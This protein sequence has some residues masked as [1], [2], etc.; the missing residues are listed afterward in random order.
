MN[1]LNSKNRLDKS[2]GIAE[3]ETSNAMNTKKTPWFLRLP[4]DI[5]RKIGLAVLAVGAL[6]LLILLNDVSAAEAKKGN[7]LT[8]NGMEQSW[9]VNPRWTAK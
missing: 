2:N 4:G 8:K 9:F 5:L 3:I 1:P 7:I 6:I